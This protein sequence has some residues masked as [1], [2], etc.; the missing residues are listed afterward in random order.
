MTDSNTG[1]IIDAAE[2][3]YHEAAELLD[4]A[5][6]IIETDV[7]QVVHRK[8]RRIQ[9]Y[10]AGI[11]R[12]CGP[13]AVSHAGVGGQSSDQDF[14]IHV[15]PALDSADVRV[16]VQGNRTLSLTSAMAASAFPGQTEDDMGGHIAGWLE[17]QGWTP[18]HQI[19]PRSVWLA[20]SPDG[21]WQDC[22]II[23]WSGYA[24]QSQWTYQPAAK[25][26]IEVSSGN[27]SLRSITEETVLVD[28]ALWD[29]R[30]GEA[31]QESEAEISQSVEVSVETHWD[32]SITLGESIDVQVSAGPVDS[33]ESLTREESWG[34]GGGTSKTVDVGDSDRIKGDV[35][36]GEAWVA[37]L[38]LRRG[39]ASVRVPSG[40]KPH[41]CALVHLYSHHH[42]HPLKIRATDG[43]EHEAS[44]LA[45]P[46]E[47]A[48]WTPQDYARNGGVIQNGV[49]IDAD[50]LADSILATH[51]I[52]P[53]PPPGPISDEVIAAA[54][55]VQPSRQVYP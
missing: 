29:N 32:H 49:T 1:A 34:T 40:A 7:A 3:A 24:V 21:Q 33:E 19:E 53:T 13:S 17:V 38:T 44:W 52:K 36:A 9:D 2:D 45:V 28:H 14:A 16:A 54:C 11:I 20:D 25:P 4:A 43:N 35:P 48:L 31:P 10:S 55:G 42:G 18:G 22:W 46:I 12:R 8:A 26:T 37:A 6:A 30:G 41:G 23:P 39:T 50:A 5:G 47:W 51:P 27:E 15:A